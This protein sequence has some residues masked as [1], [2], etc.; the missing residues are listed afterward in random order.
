MMLGERGTYFGTEQSKLDV[1]NK[2]KRVSKIFYL[3]NYTRYESERLVR[4][5]NPLAPFV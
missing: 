1:T 2:A 3:K 5:K 4:V